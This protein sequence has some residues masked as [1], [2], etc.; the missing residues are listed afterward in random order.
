MAKAKKA[1]P[2]SRSLVLTP[3]LIKKTWGNPHKLWR[4]NLFCAKSL[5]TLGDLTV[6]VFYF[7]FRW[8]SVVNSYQT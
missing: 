2:S 3:A 4:K 5:T 8:L 7:Y 1:L 6:Y